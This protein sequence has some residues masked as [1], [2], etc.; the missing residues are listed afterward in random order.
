MVDLVHCTYLI[1][2]NILD[3][4]SY[5]DG[6]KDYEYVIFSRNVRKEDIPQILDTRQ[7]YGCI[8]LTENLNNC[9]KFMENLEFE[10][11]NNK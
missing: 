1:K 7:I 2:K 5:N 3:K 9:K 8:T 6:T 10:T 11:E 4:I